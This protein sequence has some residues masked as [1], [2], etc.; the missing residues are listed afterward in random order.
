MKTEGQ[1]ASL[2]VGRPQRKVKRNINKSSRSTGRHQKKEC[3]VLWYREKLIN[4]K[5]FSNYLEP[6]DFHLGSST[7]ASLFLLQLQ[8]LESLIFIFYFP[9]AF[10]SAV[11][12]L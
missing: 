5:L 8:L 6:C 3:A 11:E 1:T 10:S 12:R 9:A 4:T 2:I 7:G